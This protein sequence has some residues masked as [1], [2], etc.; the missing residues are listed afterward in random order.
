[1]RKMGKKTKEWLKAKP[2]LV[3]I[4]KEKGITRCENC[5]SRYMMSFHHRPS[6]ASQKAIHDFKHTRLLCA[7]CHDLFEPNEELDKKLF[8]KPRGYSLKSKVMAEKKKSKKPDWSRKHKCIKCKVLTSMII[9][10]NCGELS[11][12]K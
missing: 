12:K 5:G 4:Y 6:R 7:E 11:I 1:M 10:H 2:K 9:C 8:A 3:K